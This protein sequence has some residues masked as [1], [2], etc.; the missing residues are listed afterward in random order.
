MSEIVKY[1]VQFG[2]A[3]LMGVL[4]IWERY[5]SRDYAKMLSQT[6][7]QIV[8]Q[9]TEINILV[10]LLE[11]NTEALVKFDHTQQQLCRSLSSVSE[12]LSDKGN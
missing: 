1:L 9:K 4:W 11:K 5:L 7:R 2:V 3:G 12:L 6:H 10:D 8:D